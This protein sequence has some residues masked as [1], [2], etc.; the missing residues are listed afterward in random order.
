MAS[1]SKDY[2]TPKAQLADTVT[3]LTSIMTK[4]DTQ[5]T[6]LTAIASSLGT[7]MR[8][9]TNTISTTIATVRNQGMGVATSIN[10]ANRGSRSAGG[11]FTA[12][13]AWSGRTGFC[14]ANEGPGTGT[15]LVGGTAVYG[16]AAI[17][18]GESYINETYNGNVVCKAITDTVNYA[19]AEW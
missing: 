10:N 11:A 5:I 9:L 17:K 14:I 13:N 4:L 8:T 16:L 19:Y 18:P 6:K 1:G 15:L 7:D 2:Y 3:N 12:L